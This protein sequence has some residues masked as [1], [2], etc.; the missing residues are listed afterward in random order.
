[1]ANENETLVDGLTRRLAVW[2][3]RA[4]KAETEVERL[5][6]LLGNSM[7]ASS[8]SPVDSSA[9]SSDSLIRELREKNEAL[10]VELQTIMEKI[11]TF[12]EGAHPG[13]M[14]VLQ[15][16]KLAK[17]SRELMD[18]SKEERFGYAMSE[19]T[20]VGSPRSRTSSRKGSSSFAEHDGHKGEDKSSKGRSEQQA[21]SETTPPAY[22]TSDRNIIKTGVDAQGRIIPAVPN[23]PP[24]G[25]NQEKSKTAV[26]EQSTASSKDTDSTQRTE[27][28]S[29]VTS[30]A[31]TAVPEL[32]PPQPPRQRIMVFVAQ[33]APPVTQSPSNSGKSPWGTKPAMPPGT[34]P[35]IS[36]SM[37]SSG[38]FGNMACR[39]PLKVSDHHPRQ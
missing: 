10:T 23:Q 37:M 18:T 12:D 30:V 21:H 4:E 8:Q 14:W 20:S 11:R 38:G 2:Q 22:E 17:L 7:P 9:P 1:M 25:S 35:P 39:D 19:G 28:S 6:N 36:A 3:Q 33:A 29:T 26:K 5:K 32:K 15:L 16:Q 34:G 31:S 27:S 24:T 13:S